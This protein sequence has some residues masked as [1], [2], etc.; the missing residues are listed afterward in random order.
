MENNI[1]TVV[2][3]N[4]VP[5][6][7]Y[8]EVLVADNS[9]YRIRF[10]LDSEWDSTP[11]RT[12]RFII[13]EWTTDSSF[14]GDT[15]RLPLLPSG[16]HEVGIGL[17]AGELR[18]TSAA[19]VPVMDSVFVRSGSTP[20]EAAE[21][22]RQRAEAQRAAAELERAA[23]ERE[24]NASEID[25]RAAE[26]ARVEA[27]RARAAAES[28]RR[29]AENARA[30]AEDTRLGN[31]NTRIA[32]EASR[33]NAEQARVSAE[34]QRAAA[35]TARERKEDL[36]NTA[37]TARASAET[38]RA[39]AEQ[40]RANAESARA[41]AETARVSAEQ[42]R[43]SAES[44]RANAESERASAERTR[45]DSETAR[46]A[47]EV[48]REE[49]I[50][51]VENALAEHVSEADAYFVLACIKEYGV[52]KA[53]KRF[54]ERTAPQVGLTEA[55]SAFFAAA[56]VWDDKVYASSFY[57]YSVSP[58]PVGVKRQANEGLVAVPSTSSSQG[59]DDYADIPLF[60]CFDCNYT[61]DAATLEPVIHA[62]KDVYG[63]FSAAPSNSLVGVIQMTGWVRRSVSNTEKTVEYAA[64]N[65]GVGFKPLPEAVRAS[66]NSVR[67]FV[68][69]AKYAAGF[70]S[71]SQ[72]S[73]VSG[74][75][76]VTGIPAEYGGGSIT[77][78]GQAALWRV[79]GSQ[80]GGSGI[81][82]QNFLQTM[83]EIK[84][85]NL[86][87][88]N[89]MS[90]CRNYDLNY[91]AAVSETGVRR[92]LLTPAQGR[93]LIVGS[94]VSLGTSGARADAS[95]YSVSPIK[96]IAGISSVSINGED[97]AAVSIDTDADF[98]VTQGD[99]YITTQPWRTGS[100]D[101]VYG[102]DGSPYDNLSGVEPFKLQGIEV[103]LGAD[104]VAFDT[105]LYDNAGTNP[106]NV[107]IVREATNVSTGNDGGTDSETIATI[108]KKSGSAG[109][110]YIE[111]CN[112]EANSPEGYI[113]P[114]A[115]GGT[116]STG[117]CAALWQTSGSSGR[118]FRQY[119]MC[120]NLSH[121]GTAGLACISA[122]YSRRTLSALAGCR[123]CGTAGN[124]GV[125]QD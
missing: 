49:R 83:L 75:Q 106:Y 28:A 73:S 98:D 99:T 115:T 26:S 13:G 76:P 78:D 33:A 46:A 118:G 21:I 27:E 64:K 9:E 111:E 81:C 14:I 93:T 40:A 8:G 109:A 43:A 85:A 66:D 102:S 60:A 62:I 20:A 2:V 63:E 29:S 82:E 77:H 1:L 71:L 68:I 121:A 120:G 22:E 4:K 34:Q 55:V 38:A 96:R 36:R 80:Y 67:P 123:A 17:Y 84:Y 117:Y 56:A 61:I 124:R 41:N 72:L 114:S 32:N 57:L 3:R 5:T 86:G 54:L 88:A 58:S 37:E 108:I 74:V 39:N 35:E 52:K 97:Y 53:L 92:I 87:S 10:D 100:T 50:S 15:V 42:A 79:R 30:A 23:A 94:S 45:C 104:E 122:D 95:C 101:S 70:D 18:T 6:V 107:V 24:R 44:A 116:S 12:A 47:A 31:E 103:M 19:R 16:A 119:M 112:W 89:I 105:L 91:T 69:H 48:L 59:R 125:Y 90:G 113:A 51:A 7:D 110:R 11:V 25:R 65:L